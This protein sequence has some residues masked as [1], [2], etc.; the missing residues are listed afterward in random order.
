MSRRTKLWIAAVFV[1]LPA[2][3]VVY[4]ALAWS[5]ENPLRFRVTNPL[6]AGAADPAHSQLVEIEVENTTRYPLVFFMADVAREDTHSPILGSIDLKFQQ[7]AVLNRDLT[8]VELKGGQRVRLVADLGKNWHRQAAEH[9]ARVNYRWCSAAEYWLAMRWGRFAWR[10]PG[11]IRR[12]IPIPEPS[13]DTT[14]LEPFVRDEG[15]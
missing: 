10:F 6:A 3:L 12:F 7:P 5:P 15:N 8:G 11:S 4:L 13:G 14:P 2:G 1:L 9:G